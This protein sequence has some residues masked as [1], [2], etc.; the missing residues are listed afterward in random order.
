MHRQAYRPRVRGKVWLEGNGRF[1]VGD[2]GVGLL[3]AIE[4]TGSIR[5]AAVSVGWSYRHTLAYLDNAESVLGRCLVDRK[6]GGKARGGATL[7]DEGRDF[8][9][10]Y[11]DFRQAVDDALHRLYASAFAVLLALVTV[12]GLPPAAAAQAPSTTVIVSTTTSTQDSGLLDVLV[13][14]FEKESGAKV[15]TVAV[16][17]G[18]A[19]EMGAR[20]EADVVLVHSPAAEEEMVAD[21]KGRNRRIVMHNDFVIVG[22]ASD[23]AH[24]R[25]ASATAAMARIAR[26]KAPF[27]SRGDDSGT[28]TFELKLWD[29]AGVKPAGSWYQ[30]SGQGMG[31]TLQIAADKDAYTISDRGTYLAT[32]SARDLKL[33]VEGG[34]PLLNVYHVIEIPKTNGPRVNTKGGD[35]FADWIVSPPA[36]EMI[37]TFGVEKYGEPLFTPDA[38]KTDD[39]IAEA[40]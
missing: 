10:R 28:N 18:Q 19:I 9:V 13:S 38:G 12:L 6:R 33:L 17:S 32:D 8:V 27:I 31:A 4:R 11:A 25:G 40:A 1:A 3:R 34:S 30:E 35:A 14:A 2:G 7:T 29:K 21:G 39:Q 15:K 23:P 24:I 36:Q 20:G 22:P 26:S 37:G 5:A 16:G